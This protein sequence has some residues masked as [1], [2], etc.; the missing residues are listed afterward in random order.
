MLA[1]LN[2]QFPALVNE[3]L[4]KLP[5]WV[6]K[7]TTSTFLDPSMGGG[8]FVKEIEKRLREAGHSDENISKRVF[9]FEINILRVNFA[10]YSN[11]LV[12]T[13]NVLDFLLWE[14]DMKFD[15]V[16]G[17]PPY[18]GNAALHQQFFNKAVEITK[19]G[20][21][22]S[23]V[24]P[25]TPYF[26]KKDNR[27]TPDMIMS[28]LLRQ[29]K[30]L[31]VKF[32]SYEVF[33]GKANGTTQLA[34]TTMN[35]IPSTNQQIEHLEY[36]SG[37]VEKNVHINAVNELEMD[38]KSFALLQ[39]K[40]KNFVDKNGSLDSICGHLPKGDNIHRIP[41]ITGS[42]NENRYYSI[43]TSN[44]EGFLNSVSHHEKYWSV[45]LRPSES[46][47][48]FYSF[49]KTF[50]ARF[51]LTFL[52]YN[53][54]NENGELRAVPLVP[55]DKSWTDEELARAIGLTDEELNL[56]K[57]SLSDYHGLLKNVE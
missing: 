12:G 4:D 56:I 32:I 17:N 31:D 13:Y 51:G 57:S 20:G 52:K 37:K 30:I 34:I 16:I 21:F 23:F 27:K 43:I 28:R 45:Q 10:V 33:S 14:S 46:L 54:H 22:V 6:W 41:Y 29:Y 15:V 35:K 53:Q 38:G 3:M 7:S 18:K 44:M 49:A 42:R 55:F 24:Q 48:H 47:E 50:V 2:F 5:K 36:I 8:Q 19:D 11:N 40:Y 39:K 9:G 1:R 25:A 26:N